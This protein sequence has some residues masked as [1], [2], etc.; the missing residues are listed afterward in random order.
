MKHLFARTCV[1]ATLFFPF[2]TYASFLEEFEAYD[3][4]A[5]LLDQ[6][7]AKVKKYATDERLINLFNQHN[8]N[9]KPFK[10]W[11]MTLH[12]GTTSKHAAF[13]L[14]DPDDLARFSNLLSTLPYQ[15]IG[16]VD[17]NPASVLSVLEEIAEDFNSMKKNKNR[18]AGAFKNIILRL[19][20]VFLGIGAQIAEKEI[21]RVVTTTKD[22]NL[23][24]LLG[25]AKGA[26]NVT[27]DQVSSLVDNELAENTV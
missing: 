18:V 1:L 4:L 20:K 14:S 19:G 24:L 13:D 6:G 21:D 26:V 8:L 15:K 9:Y 5:V 2:G 7:G 17:Q 16:R 22:E 11:V 23:K 10:N 27:V 25:G 3:D 12:K